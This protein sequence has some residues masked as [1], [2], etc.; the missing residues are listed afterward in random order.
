MATSPR[1]TATLSDSVTSLNPLSLTHTF[2]HTRSVSVYIVFPCP[3]VFSFSTYSLHPLPFFLSSQRK[4]IRLAKVYDR[5]VELYPKEAVAFFTST[6]FFG[7]FSDFVKGIDEA[8]P[9]IPPEHKKRMVIKARQEA[10]AVEIFQLYDLIKK[11][12]WQDVDPAKCVLDDYDVVA[13]QFIATTVSDSFCFN[14][15]A[16]CTPGLSGLR[17]AAA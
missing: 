8:L 14:Q 5:F 6:P 17:G 13:A 16:T 11:Q 9:S 2:S 15:L 4:P 7:R 12:N 10:S 3:F 1:R